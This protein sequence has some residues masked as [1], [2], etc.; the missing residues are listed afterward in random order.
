MTFFVYSAIFCKII[1]FVKGFFS[2][3]IV[4]DVM[5][6]SWKKCSPNIGLWCHNFQQK[7]GGQF[8]SEMFLPTCP[9]EP[10]WSVSHYVHVYL[11][12]S[13]CMSLI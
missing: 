2:F 8:F 12:P 5:E 6:T 11:R 7:T 4:L 13:V 1:F 10:S 3:R 9:S